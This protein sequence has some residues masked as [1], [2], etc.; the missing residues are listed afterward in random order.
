[1]PGIIRDGVIVI[2]ATLAL[3]TPVPAEE[4][5]HSL[6]DKFAGAAERESANREAEEHAAK[7]LDAQ[8]KAAEQRRSE[9]Q[10]RRAR[11]EAQA[12]A[13][14]VEDA[15]RLEEAEMLARARLEAEQR[16]TAEEEARIAEESRRLIQQA[17]QER[18][19]AA[20]ILAR[21]AAGAEGR[22]LAAQPVSPPVR[23]EI[24]DAPRPS[25]EEAAS[26]EP[27]KV[28][29][30]RPAVADPDPER[31]AETHAEEARRL[32]EKLKRV[33]QIREARLVARATEAAA[34]A[35][36]AREAEETHL[37]E[38]QR[39][40]AQARAAEVRTIAMRESQVREA[41]EQEE[42]E[43]RTRLSLATEAP[44][45]DAT[46]AT[47][48]QESAETAGTTDASGLREER[49]AA[50]ER[51]ATGGFETT[52]SPPYE[53]P[54]LVAND[55]GPGSQRLQDTR[56]TVLL[57]L[58][59]GTYG[60][61]RGTRTADPILCLPDGCYLS[62]GAD[63]PA[64]FLPGRRALAFGNIWGARA[65]A[66]SGN[67]GCVFRNVDLGQI[68]GHLQPVDLHILKQEMGCA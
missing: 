38:V 45:S 31:L 67:L 2:A 68:P 42:A 7:L 57:T 40:E 16:R 14:K 41:R 28:A 49:S 11:A 5:A 37:R 48:A 36:Q 4:T 23:S 8:R 50:S 66:C 3:S 1:M 35:A 58:Q 44:A 21:E 19:K 39:R 64:H 9:E 55:G 65:A 24:A 27:V 32:S 15:R 18:M 51:S 34:R 26:T 47:R 29:V 20:D 56:V 6:A 60:I 53:T 25:A 54:P 10:K 12:E 62:L 43:E 13:R 33:R 63:R 17:E 22:A 61:R 52:A 59:P 46:Q 30:P